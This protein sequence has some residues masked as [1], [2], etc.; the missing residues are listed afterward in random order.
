[1]W[2]SQ[3]LHEQ[4]SS[5]MSTLTKA[6]LMQMCA[7]VDQGFTAW[8]REIQRKQQ[9]NEE[10]RK[11]LHLIESII[12]SGKSRGR[13]LLE[14]TDSAGST[15]SQVSEV[16]GIKDEHLDSGMA[17]GD[18]RL[19]AHSGGQQMSLGEESAPL[20]SPPEAGPSSSTNP[21]IITIKV[22]SPQVSSHLDMDVQSSA[23]SELFLTCSSVVGSQ[24]SEQ[25]NALE[26]RT[27]SDSDSLILNLVSVS[28]S[29]TDFKQTSALELRNVEHQSEASTTNQSCMST[30][31]RRVK[32]FLCTICQKRFVT[33]QTLEVHI[34]I[35][36]GERPFKCKQ[37]ER[38]FNQSCH[39][40]SH[41]QTVH[42][43]SKPHIC[44]VC[45][46]GFSLESTL[47]RHM[48]RWHP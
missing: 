36:T 34:R 22:E 12:Q 20:S 24:M 15:R 29:S 38:R 10:L 39:L 28:D 43:P 5:I 3:A 7:A 13:P 17:C 23:Y 27:H 31:T 47:Q 41:Y 46:R 16:T 6:A 14:L 9:E 32:R 42:A 11:K 40:K 8:Q 25:K 26:T 18:G 4:L 35:H 44:S 2:N 30:Q 33:A 21:E 1:M 19:R 45:N 37:C 48:D